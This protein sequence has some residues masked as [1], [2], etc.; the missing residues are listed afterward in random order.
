MLTPDAA[1][2]PCGRIARADNSPTN[3]IRAGDGPPR[4]IFVA[5]AS[6][7]LSYAMTASRFSSWYVKT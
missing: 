6:L 2:L 5:H 7:D 1:P 4:S 3:L